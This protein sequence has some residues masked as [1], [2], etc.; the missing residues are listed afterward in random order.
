M[1]KL[2]WCCVLPCCRRIVYFCSFSQSRRDS[3]CKDFGSRMTD[4]WTRTAG[5]LYLNKKHANN[6]VNHT[7]SYA[8]PL[9]TYCHYRGL[10]LCGSQIWFALVTPPVT[11]REVW[12]TARVGKEASFNWRAQSWL[13]ETRP[14]SEIQR[15]ENIPKCWGQ[16]TN[17]RQRRAMT[18]LLLVLSI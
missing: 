6:Y 15:G 4:I 2:N 5:N 8:S 13:R 12:K 18:L 1:K 10:S 9:H 17:A 7:D 11:Q 14:P 16:R 3:L